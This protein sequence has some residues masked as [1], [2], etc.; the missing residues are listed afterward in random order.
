MKS[1]SKHIDIH[2]THRTFV[3]ENHIN[4]NFVLNLGDVLQINNDARE[5]MIEISYIDEHKIKLITFG[6]DLYE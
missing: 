3:E 1:K 6:K 2:Y 4:S 5:K